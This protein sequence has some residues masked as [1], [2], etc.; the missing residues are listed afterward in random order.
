[1]DKHEVCFRSVTANEIAFYR[2]FGWVKL[3]KFVPL[4]LVNELLAIAKERMGE[5]GDR[6]APPEAFSYFNPCTINGLGHPVFGP[7]IEHIA[8]NAKLLLARKVPVGIRYFT[9]Y[10]GAKLPSKKRV[11]HGGAG[12]SDWH[13][14]YTAAA[15]DRSGGM[16]FWL[17][18][19]D[20]GPEKGTMAFLNGSHRYG[21]LGH[22]TTYEGG[23]LLDV[24]PEIGEE[25]SSSGNLS[26][27]GG[28]VTVHSNLCVHSAGLNL[29]D[30]PRWTYM[31][32]V[33]PADVRWNGGPAD[34]FDTKGLRLW[35]EMEDGRFPILA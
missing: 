3:E 7:V 21:V 17:A 31:V 9:D 12:S 25:C 19:T 13:Q 32:I 26:Y 2:Q 6:N 23:N 15:S 18:L 4:A 35:E 11:N 1:M 24:Y 16:V 28:D 14:D 5:D 30:E 8:R 27:V 10:Y 29:T 34:A 22:Y 33:N 20:M